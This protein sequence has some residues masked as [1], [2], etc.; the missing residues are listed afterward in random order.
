MYSLAPP[1]SCAHTRSTIKVSEEDTTWERDRKTLRLQE[2]V[3]AGVCV[4]LFVLDPAMSPVVSVCVC[5]RVCGH[6]CVCVRIVYCCW[7]VACSLRAEGQDLQREA[8]RLR[9]HLPVP[10]QYVPGEVGP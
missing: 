9:P 3:A 5:V 1:P 10:K 2:G 4:L 7:H 8:R 6:G